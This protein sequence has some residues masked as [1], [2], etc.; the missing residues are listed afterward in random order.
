MIFKKCVRKLN[1]LIHKIIFRIKLMFLDDEWYCMGG[2]CF[3]F[4]PPS[5]YCTH[6]PE[7]IERITAEKIEKIQM[8]I[9]EL[10]DSYLQNRTNVL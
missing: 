3:G 2:N 4:F 10:D 7:E 8:A 5:F 9:E 1:E 6:T